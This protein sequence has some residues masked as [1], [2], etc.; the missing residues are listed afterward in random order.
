MTKGAMP[1]VAIALSLVLCPPGSGAEGNGRHLKAAPQISGPFEPADGPGPL[2]VQG[3]PVQPAEVEA[4]AAK[5][6]GFDLLADGA[7]LFGL[8]YAGRV[9]R[10]EPLR[11][12]AADLS[13]WTKAPACPPDRVLVDP[14]TGRARFFTGDDPA[15]FQS[16]VIA[17]FRGTHGDNAIPQWRGDTLFLSHWESAYNVWAYDV[18]DPR[19]PRKTGEL[20][21]ANFAHGFVL[22]DSGFALMG[23][24]GKGML[25]LDLR[26]PARMA[27]VKPVL[28]KTDWLNLIS[29]RYVAAWAKEAG[30]RDPRVYDASKLPDEFPEVMASVSADV[31][32]HLGGGVVGRSPEGAT[33]F[34]AG[35]NLALVDVRAAPDEWRVLRVIRLPGGDECQ[36]RSLSPQRFALLYTAPAKAERDKEKKPPAPRRWLQVLDAG[37]AGP[38]FHPPLEVSNEA[39]SLGVV[40]GPYTYLTVRPKD[41]GAGVIGTYDG[42][43]QEIYDLSDPAKPA[44]AGSWDLGV[45]FRDLSLHPRPDRKGQV[46]ALEPGG[47]FGFHLCDFSDPLKPQ[48]LA[49]VPTN[50]E[51]NRVA[52]WGGRALFTSSTLG[53][54]FDVSSPLEPKLLGEWLNHRWFYVRHLFGETALVWSDRVG[55]ELVDFHDPKL[56]RARAKAEGQVGW[57][58]LVCSVRGGR[59]NGPVTLSLMDIADPAHPATRFSGKVLDER[60]GPP[61]LAGTCVEGSILYA[62]SEGAKGKAVLLVFDIADPATPRLV[63]TFNHPE[64]EV[65]RNQGFWTAQGHVLTAGRGILL[66]TSY[67][68]GAPQV[69]DARDPGAP[70]FLLRLPVKGSEWVDAWPDGPWFLIKSYPDGVQIWDFRDPAKPVRIWEEQSALDYDL[71]AWQAGVPI[72]EVLLAP[73]L[74]HLKVMTIPRPSQVP[75]GRLTWR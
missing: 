63:A 58:N 75:A 74:P 8:E 73:K 46:L 66:V 54:W 29:P 60:E 27:V 51:G 18:T 44:K 32:K 11:P 53:L 14:R 13:D 50:G 10:R 5:P 34:A 39:S 16:R 67:G 31:R 48:V 19:A 36:V 25:L 9:G 57:G 56:P 17:R 24:T 49:H 69:I 2:T 3:H 42:T 30:W 37:G 68:S 45:P 26:D 38:L 28:P 55:G 65:R 15:G 12:L 62:I 33:W 4:L 59:G 6:D 61:P 20:A 40:G 41:R 21:V 47:G 23:T 72:G 7:S 64:L 70:K 43:H 71:H 22:L 52:A 1:A 35:Q